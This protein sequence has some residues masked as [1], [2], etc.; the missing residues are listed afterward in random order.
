MQAV[1]RLRARGIEVEIEAFAGPSFWQTQELEESDELL[2]RSFAALARLAPPARGAVGAD[3]SLHAAEAAVPDEQALG[4]RCGDAQVF[5]ILN[6][7]PAHTRVES[8]AVVI[9]VGGP[10]YRVGSHRQF[11]LLARRL[12]ENGFASLRFDY[13]GMGD[14]EGD[15]RSFDDVG[16]DLHAAID[17]L[18]GACATARRIVVWGLCDAASAAMIHAGSHAAVSGIVAVN[19]WARSD[20]SLAAT[21]VKHYYVGRLLDGEFWVK[22]MR[23]Q[24][25]VRGAVR[26]LYRNLKQAWG[27][28]R[29]SAGKGRHDDSFQTRMARGIAGFRGRILLILAGNDL[30]AKE[31]LHYTA[32][33][34][35]WRGVLDGARISRVDVA[36]SDHTFSCRAW[37][38]QVEDATID[39]LRG[40]GA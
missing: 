22:L 21:H 30:T 20:A 32:T 25:D 27:P 34:S 5:A 40:F 3:G 31:F 37:R 17:A 15:T 7:P 29:A 11:V 33:S 38:R 18:Q 35:A 4:F 14:S 12:A 13:R 24:L 36:E 19:P 1:E 23:G 8:T 28:A 39:W 16:P 2:R 9:A 26:T 6:R 10:Q